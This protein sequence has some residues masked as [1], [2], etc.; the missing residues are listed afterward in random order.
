M[1]SYVQHSEQ[2]LKASWGRTDIATE[3]RRDFQDRWSG[4][5]CS[6]APNKYYLGFQ[7][8]STTECSP[9][10]TYYC[11]T[12]ST[13][14]FTQQT[15]SQRGRLWTR[16]PFGDKKKLSLILS[17]VRYRARAPMMYVSFFP[18]ARCSAMIQITWMTFPSAL[19]WCV[20]GCR[21]A[22]RSP[23]TKLPDHKTSGRLLC[24]NILT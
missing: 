15:G 11:R 10:V 24:S 7:R 4:G 17:Q 19:H 8:T 5:Y 1:R 14:L 16:C 21:F 20:P 3:Q 6:N 12:P 18:I 9:F 13:N 22:G 23:S 2:I